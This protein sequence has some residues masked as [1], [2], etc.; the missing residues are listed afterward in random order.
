MPLRGLAGGSL[1]IAVVDDDPVQRLLLRGLLGSAGIDDVQ[2]READSASELRLLLD[3]WGALDIVLLDH[4]LGDGE[5]VALIG[6]I[7]AVDPDT[8]VIV[9]TARADDAL[10]RAAS[11]G[12]AADVLTKE[13]LSVH[14]LGRSL[15]YALAQREDR[16]ALRAGE[17][18]LRLMLRN[19]PGT[20][21]ALYDATLRIVSIDGWEDDPQGRTEQSVRGMP[22]SDFLAAD[23]FARLEPVLRA[24]LSGEPSTLQH[25]S[26]DGRTFQLDIAPFRGEGEQITGV[27]TVWRDIS[28]QAAEQRARLEAEQRF[29][30]AFEL[31]PIGMAIVDLKGRIVQANPA[32]AAL[33][34]YAIA[35]LQEMGATDFT[36]PDDRRLSA[37]TLAD[38]AAGDGSTVRT[39]RRWL[40][41]DGAEIW[42][43]IRSSVV[44]DAD[45]RPVHLLG[46][47]IDIT[48]RRRLQLE[49]QHLADH[50]ALTGVLNRRG[51]GRVL[52]EHIARVGRYGGEGALMI[53][54]LDGFK[55]INDSVG[56]D[57]GD[58]LLISVS[59][60]L[61]R[62]LRESDFVGRLGG[63]EFAV[64]LPKAD[65]DSAAA[66]ATKLCRL[67]AADASLDTPGARR[68]VTASIGIRLFAEPVPRQDK[69]LADADR[70]MYAAKQAG[71]DGFAFASSSAASSEAGATPGSTEPA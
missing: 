30:Q 15:R 33:T 68:S 40:R 1:R 60:A 66:V 6:E 38:L 48:E 21:V 42:V 59:A 34:G 64:L 47:I 58:R 11:A 27:L 10:D 71:R 5:G 25:V 8:T 53:L 17:Q 23:A 45:G 41:A 16:R 44:T 20:V 63:D 9:I 14:S 13:E 12:G 52:D 54:D 35:E 18:R 55:D 3:R 57:A 2:V 28:E 31:A 26:S 65:H 46:Q 36:H 7:R 61:S 43:S 69:A 50:D 19:L 51:F 37:R 67:I 62:N 24:A 56:H 49:L 22:A 29:R 70:A 4:E 32:L 39:E